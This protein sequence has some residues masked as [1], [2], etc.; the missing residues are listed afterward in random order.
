MR[1]QAD[2]KNWNQLIRIFGANFDILN[3]A[4]SDNDFSDVKANAEV[5]DGEGIVNEGLPS[6]C[7]RD[8]IEYYFN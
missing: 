5:D 4:F 7:E 2:A 1:A 6:G 3:M 8:L